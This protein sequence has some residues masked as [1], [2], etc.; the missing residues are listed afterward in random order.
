MDKERK[1]MAVYR[2]NI[3]SVEPAANGLV[4]ADIFIQIRTAT[5]PITWGEIQ[6]GHRTIVLEA[7]DIMAI[8]N[9]PLNNTAARRRAAINA[10][11]KA[12]AL[13][14]GIDTADEA[15]VAIM[16]LYDFPF[17]VIIRDI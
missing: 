3:N 16:G 13:E 14:L 2:V 9:D 15:Y 11:I 5:N 12:K 17:D 8:I 4:Y 10:K 1:N 6:N 7:S